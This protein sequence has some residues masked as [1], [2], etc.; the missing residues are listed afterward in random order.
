MSQGPSLQVPL[1]TL[2][3]LPLGAEA[4]ATVWR[5]A[6][7]WTSEP[8]VR[9]RLALELAVLELDRCRELGETQG[10]TAVLP[11]LE[12]WEATWQNLCAVA[13]DDEL[14]ECEPQWQGAMERLLTA[15][16]QHLNTTM[17]A[18]PATETET[19]ELVAWAEL[20][21]WC[22]QRRNPDQGDEAL[23][24][25]LCR[26][27]AIA[28]SALAGF[29]RGTPAALEA[30]G[31]AQVLLVA[32]AQQTPADVVW[33][34]NALQDG[35]ADHLAAGAPADRDWGRWLAWAE[36]IVERSPSAVERERRERELWPARA[37]LEIA[38]TL[39]V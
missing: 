6:M 30:S 7:G 24:E 9:R 10:W 17:Q 20:L 37:A 18:P 12:G 15:L 13:S 26:L 21:W 27:G 16:Q 39:G 33:I 34:R 8:A 22:W 28:W 3:E 19:P 38:E 36:L 1:E 5:E 14:A 23:R 25:R 35:L 4:L 31:R 32:L 11:R 29:R 2:L